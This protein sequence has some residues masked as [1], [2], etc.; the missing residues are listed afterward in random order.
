MPAELHASRA[1]GNRASGTWLAFEQNSSMV[2]GGK[3]TIETGLPSLGN[4]T[5]SMC[6]LD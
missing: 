4:A 2:G 6:S 5:N 3:V 1:T